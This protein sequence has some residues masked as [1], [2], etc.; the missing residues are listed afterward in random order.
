MSNRRKMLVALGAGVFTIPLASFAQQQRKVWRIG[1]LETIPM[2]LNAANMNAFRLG[3][4][5]LGYV[6]G[7]NLVI[8]YRSADG[9]AEHFPDLASELVRLKVDLIVTRGTPAT[10]AAN[11]AS[12]TIPV[13]TTAVGDPLLFGASLARPGGNITG[14]TSITPALQPKRI[15]ILMATVPGVARFAALLNMA[16][17][18][19]PREWK[20]IETVARSLGVQPLLLDVRK[21]EDIGPAFDA[22]ISQHANA[23]A[24]GQE[25]LIQA[26]A[27]LIVE[28]AAKHRLPAIYSS[29][30]YVDAGGFISYGLNYPDL[31]HRTAAF[32]DRILRGT[33]PGDLPFEQPTRFELA[34]NMIT[35]KALG[36]KI[37]DSVL[38]QA[39]NVIE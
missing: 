10:Y 31:Y 23:L 37:P 38:V 26:N 24:V 17:G 2:A 34:I 27:D 16:N 19:I 4:R 35:A 18:T 39:T 1:M 14:M 8:E 12:G 5:E 9:R 22:A 36:I 6:E 29:R 21:P 3:L 7:Q 25:T 32:V 28:Y 13:V 11:K 33:K 15:D 20:E 30:E